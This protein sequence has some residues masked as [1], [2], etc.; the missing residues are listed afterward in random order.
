MDETAT[1]GGN[2]MSSRGDKHFPVVINGLEEFLHRSVSSLAG[3]PEGRAL[4]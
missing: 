3:E 1:L 2:G 4:T